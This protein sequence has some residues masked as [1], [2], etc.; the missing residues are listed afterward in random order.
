MV[1]SNPTAGAFFSVAQKP[2][3]LDSIRGL[4]HTGTYGKH[5]EACVLVHMVTRF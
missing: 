1:G 2:L 5:D 3:E 4:E